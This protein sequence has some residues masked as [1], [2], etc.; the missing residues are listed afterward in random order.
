MYI[1]LYV[2]HR[3]YCQIL[4][5]LGFS[6]RFFEKFLHIRFHENPSRGR[7]V[8]CRLLDGQT[9]RRT[10]GQ[11][12]R[13]TERHDETNIRFRNFAKAPKNYKI[14]S[15]FILN[16]TENTSVPSMKELQRI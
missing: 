9:K 7:R 5:K 4:I 8:S 13:Q 11:K 12:G 1:G 2:K 10:D 16:I 15:P 6:R 14:Y 3:Y